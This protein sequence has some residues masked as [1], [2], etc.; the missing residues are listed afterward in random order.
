MG[1]RVHFAPEP[2]WRDLAAERWKIES[3]RI[4]ALL[5]QADVQH[6]GSTAVPGSLTKGDIDIQVRVPQDAFD[7]ADAKLAGV[8][9]RNTRSIRTST[10]SAFEDPDAS[11]PL[12]VQL[13]AIGGELDILWKMR[14]VLLRRPDLVAVR[15]CVR[16]KELP[17][18]RRSS[19]LTPP[20]RRPRT[21]G[22]RA[23]P[24]KPR[25]ATRPRALLRTP[26]AIPSESATG[27]P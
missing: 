22:H 5:P 14:E 19:W 16:R 9:R 21:S 13:T 17:T 27:R 1:S 10:F 8:Y 23:A 26:C 18:C 20:P 7:E 15:P 25:T 3:E 6:V 4:L 24:R 11:P 2:E 12:G